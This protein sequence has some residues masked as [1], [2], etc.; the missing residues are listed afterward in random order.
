MQPE[1]TFSRLKRKK[2]GNSKMNMGVRKLWIV[3]LVAGGLLL[4]ACVE[5]TLKLPAKVSFGLNILSDSSLHFIR[6]SSAEIR[7]REFE[8][9]GY[10]Q[11][12]EDYFFVH[13]FSTPFEVQYNV[14]VYPDEL[15]FDIPQGVYT[16]MK[17]KVKMDELKDGTGSPG[18]E[19]EREDSVDVEIPEQSSFVLRGFYSTMYGREIP[20]LLLIDNENFEGDIISNTSG[21]GIVISR[22]KDYTGTM[23]I[24]AGYAFKALSRHSLEDAELMFANHGET[25]VISK[26]HNDDIFEIL[27]YRLQQS[28][29]VILE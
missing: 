15:T 21:N 4:H 10:R 8:F 11:A 12:G 28:F 1:A 6:F 25:M 27:L 22:D 23:T 2:P 18:S 26:D 19:K 3:G 7:I 24:H 16:K 29:S 17:V 20:F 13:N 9:E 5:D 14:P